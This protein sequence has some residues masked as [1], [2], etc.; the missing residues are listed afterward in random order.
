MKAGTQTKAERLY[1]N[2]RRK[3]LNE[4]IPGV[5]VLPIISYEINGVYYVTCSGDVIGRTNNI[6]DLSFFISS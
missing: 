2:F 4:E 6:K 1:Q 3:S 5:T